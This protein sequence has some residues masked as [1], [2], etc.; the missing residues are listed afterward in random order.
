MAGFGGLG[1]G[2]GLLESGPRGG[3]GAAL[4]ALG[5]PFSA[6]ALGELLGTGGFAVLGLLFRLDA[7][8]SAKPRSSLTSRI[9]SQSGM[10]SC[11]TNV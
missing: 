2:G 6:P 4:G 3:G 1:A 10:L 11:Q 5:N 7:L 9:A 8:P